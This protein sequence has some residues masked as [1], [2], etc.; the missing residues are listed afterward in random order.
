MVC[1]KVA[2]ARLSAQV[3]AGSGE[4]FPKISPGF[5]WCAESGRFLRMFQQKFPQLDLVPRVWQVPAKVPTKVPWLDLVRR[6]WHVPANVP[7]FD[8]VRRV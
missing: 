4:G 5:F 8:F 2:P 1:P 3:L 7:T 6:V